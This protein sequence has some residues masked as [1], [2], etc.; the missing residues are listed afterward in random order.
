MKPSYPISTHAPS[1][2]QILRLLMAGTMLAGIALATLP[3]IVAQAADITVTT[4]EDE[5][6]ADG[7]CSLRE[8][9]LAANLNQAVD[10]CPAGTGYDN[11]H[12]PAGTFTF[13]LAGNEASGL[14]GDL[15]ILESLSIE[16]SGAGMTTIDAN[17]LDRV[18]EI[19]N[20]SQVHISR[21]SLTGGDPGISSGGGIRLIGSLTLD[22]AR[23]WNNLNGRGIYALN[24]STLTVDRSRI[25]SNQ[26]GGL[27]LQ[28]NV[29]TTI[30]S[31]TLSNNTDT[32][33]G[34]AISNS[35]ILNITNSTLS[36]NTAVGDGGGIHSNGTV[37]LNSVTITNNT[38]G[39]SG[40]YG[41]G[42]GISNQ[43]TV[44]LRNTIIAGNFDG[45]ASAVP[46]CNGAL[47]SDGYN[48]LGDTTGC[49]LSGDLTGNLTGVNPLLDILQ[50]NG[51][52]TY[53][54]ALLMGSPAINAGN[55]A[56]C[57]DENGAA[58]TIDQRGFVRLN[59]CDM[60]AYEY[61]SPGFPPPTQ[62]PLV[63]LTPTA[64]ITVPA[65]T[66]TLTPTRTPIPTATRTPTSTVSP[67]AT[68]S[69]T[70]SQT[71]SHTPPNTAT[72]TATVSHTPGPSP[73]HDPAS[74]ATATQLPP[75]NLPGYHI[76]LPMVVK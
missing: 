54:H 10:N 53:T 47:T 33:S 5:I 22:R 26:G 75:V 74:T 15:D 67:T 56:G 64:S 60:G 49:T 48:L 57:S 25:E 23:I 38:A 63:S 51:G 76:H 70:P 72:S 41:N 44:T 43:G 18:L 71:P 16:G 55:S 21:L 37:T 52:A 6:N 32:S 73:T 40:T 59:R 29:T 27:F 36:G 30:R 35:G 12:L 39:L 66:A 28:V 9:V 14:A 50:D 19:L 1:G 20:N 11:I 45:S 61:N 7:D 13:S 3:G 58:L 8:A 65:P 17:G 62:T 4:F 69:Q 31:S 42:G 24:G 68:A 46:D 34:G 2:A